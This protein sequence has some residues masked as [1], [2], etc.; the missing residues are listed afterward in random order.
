MKTFVPIVVSIILAPAA[1]VAAG[2]TW[3]HATDPTCGGNSPCFATLS[4]GI[5]NVDDGGTV[6][7]LASAVDKIVD[8]HGKRNI[9]VRGVNDAVLL[10]GNLNLAADEPAVGWTIQ[11]V[12]F[13]LGIV[14]R[15]IAGSITIDNVGA[16]AIKLGDFDQD[17]AANITIRGVS[18]QQDPAALISI[19]ATAG[20]DIGGSIMIENCVGI[21]AI[22]INA[23]VLPADPALI[24]ADITIR[25]ND[26]LQGGGINVRGID[27]AGPGDIT[28][29][30]EFSGNVM[31][32]LTGKFGVTLFGDVTGGI[33]GPVT[34]DGNNGAWLAVLTTS[35]LAGTIGA[36]TFT[37]N[38]A[39]AI[40]VVATGDLGGPVN[41]SDNQVIDLGGGTGLDNPLLLLD[42]SPLSADVVVENTT[43]PAAD[44]VV[45]SS[46]G[47]LTGTVRMENNTA[48][49]MT[50]DS[51]DGDLMMPFT[52]SGNT[53]PPAAAPLS[54][55]TIRSLNGGDSAGGSIIGNSADRVTINFAG[56]L[57]GH[58][59]TSLN[60]VG[61]D[62]TFIAAGGAGAGTH[63]VTGNDFRGFSYF[64]GMSSSVRFNRVV[65]RMTVVA[66][67][68]V[69]G[70]YNWW[71]CNAGPNQPGCSTAS[72]GVFEFSP[73]LILRSAL[74]CVP[75]DLTVSF[76]LLEASDGAVPAGN[77]TPGTV[78]I[79]S[80]AGTVTG[81][82]AVLVGGAG[83]ALVSLPQGTAQATV[84][85]ELDNQAVDTLWPC[86][87]L[88][89]ADGFESADTTAW[90]QLQAKVCACL[91][92]S[93][94]S[95]GFL[96]CL[97][98]QS[99]PVTGRD[100]LETRCADDAAA[101]RAE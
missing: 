29:P 57:N 45:R 88:I 3:V 65:D 95:G 67:A 10:T 24:T 90:D 77:T 55:V 41:V 1:A 48:G 86:A 4:L 21:Y 28:G 76:D 92:V 43:A 83:T 94:G 60:T 81:S 8:N 79:T 2:T 50:L 47:A 97:E 36:L 27:A 44:I 38:V 33:A 25:N 26:V 53:L 72:I 66:G 84:T 71:G 78:T 46:V 15:S 61:A 32:P 34:F 80:T 52:V 98:G 69:D 6:I 99:E 54:T 89:F 51:R 49:L 82:P 74:S 37:N 63:T 17:V 64:D 16:A 96:R 13:T 75:P 35:T 40:E 39:E 85:S 9:T 18:M 12:N 58:L 22:N 31:S 87:S 68:T 59:T 91:D 62:A 56:A 19:I 73:H 30:I 5:A 93:G 23:D 7:V 42:G 100:Q 70:R 11:D 101:T 20:A 14:I